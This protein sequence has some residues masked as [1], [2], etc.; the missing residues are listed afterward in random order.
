MRGPYTGS[1]ESS[2]LTTSVSWTEAA[3]VDRLDSWERFWVT[4]SVYFTWRLQPEGFST[5]QVRHEHSI[6][7]GV[8]REEVL[9]LWTG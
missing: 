5:N 1:L 2:T 3:A 8:T 4:A 6:P 7:L 9:W